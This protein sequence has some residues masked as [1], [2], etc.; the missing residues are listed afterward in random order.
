MLQLFLEARNRRGRARRHLRPVP[1][2]VR[3]V[4]HGHSG[5]VWHSPDALHNAMIWAESGERKA[6]D[7]VCG[8]P[9]SARHSP[10]NVGAAIAA[11]Y[12]RLS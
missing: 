1:R 7:E 5:D 4:C 10:L 3:S 11:K 8:S 9:L 6:G 12:T 2:S